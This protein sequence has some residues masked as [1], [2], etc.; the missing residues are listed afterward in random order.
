[1]S[2]RNTLIS[3]SMCLFLLGPTLVLGLQKAGVE[4]PGW[5][6]S[7]EATYWSGD[8]SDIDLEGT[9]SLNAFRHK[10][11]Q[12]V[13]EAKIN[14]NIP[15]KT[16]ALLG[17]ATS[18]RF[19]IFAS[20]CLF[21]FE[22]IP[23]RYSDTSTLLDCSLNAL[24]AYP[25]LGTQVYAEK[26]DRFTEA[27]L[28]FASRYPQIHFCVVIADVSSVAPSSP[29]MDLVA[30]PFL[31]PDMQGQMDHVFQTSENIDVVSITYADSQEYYRHYYASD[32]HWN[33]YGA[34]DAYNAIA[35]ELN[36]AKEIDLKPQSGLD[37]IRMNG[38][39]ARS[40]LYQANEP[41]AE[42][43]FDLDG[44]S[45]SQDESIPVLSKNGAQIMHTNPLRAEFSFYEF[46]YGRSQ[47][48]T[49]TNVQDGIEGNG[50]LICDSYGTALKYLLAKNHNELFVH[51]DLSVDTKTVDATL[52]E[53][54]AESACETVYFVAWPHTLTSI[55]DKNP[56]YF[57]E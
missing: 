32:H 49:L 16:C 15:A 27:L 13:L 24:M 2:I 34:V 14:E 7:Y 33:G 29:A 35:D 26:T 55:L 50:L 21:E 52:K 17:C 40:A 12:T 1:M 53:R 46:W 28:D 10:E 45:A 54:V 47:D 9:M 30:D 3:L 37:Q 11:F 38:S 39:Y 22:C 18:E 4:L 42:P 8:S 41:A 48:F 25:S 23:S 19:A 51:Y 56:E 6:S 20:N 5:L 57:Q 31:A 44:I 36:Y 43:H